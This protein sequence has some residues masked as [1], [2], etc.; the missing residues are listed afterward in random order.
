MTELRT[1]YAADRLRA[2]S[3]CLDTMNA[4]KADPLETLE[5]IAGAIYDDLV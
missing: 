1:D 3:E 4:G 2:V 5:A